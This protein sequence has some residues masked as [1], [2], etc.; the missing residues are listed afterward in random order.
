MQIVSQYN[1]LLCSSF[2]WTCQFIVGS[3]FANK[4]KSRSEN[5]Y[6]ICFMGRSEQLSN[7]RWGF[8]DGEDVCVDL[9]GFNVVWICREIPAFR[10]NILRP[11][12]GLNSLFCCGE[13]LIW[14]IMA[15]WATVSFSRIKII[16]PLMFSGVLFPDAFISKYSWMCFCPVGP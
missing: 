12:S 10:R 4:L 16:L 6:L 9:L 3:R 7:M 8:R 1:N 5:L 11:S 2:R 14:S 13:S 15:S